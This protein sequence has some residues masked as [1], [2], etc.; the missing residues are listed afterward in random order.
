MAE[1]SIV[2]ENLMKD[3]D[4]TPYCGNPTPKREKG[5]CSCPRTHFN[6]DIKQFSCSECGWVSRF[7][8]EFI[9]RYINKHSL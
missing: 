1:T 7:D 5:G 4:Y 9:H 2:R 8:K 3:K 6:K